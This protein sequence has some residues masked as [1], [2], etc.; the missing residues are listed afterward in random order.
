MMTLEHLVLALRDLLGSPLQIAAAVA[1]GLAFA[2]AMGSALSRT[3]LP[4]RWLAVAANVGLLVFGLVSPSLPALL[5]AVALLPVTFVRAIEITQLMRRM[6]RSTL[7]A[8]Q[9]TLWLKPYMKARKLKAGQILFSKGDKAEYLYLLMQGHLEL[10]EIQKPL[11][12]GHI[13]GEIAL[14]SPERV[15]T[16]TARCVTPCTILQI[17]D[18]TVK[19]LYYQ[20]PSFG[21][22]LIDLLASRL[23]ADVARAEAQVDRE[24]QLTAQV[25]QRTEELDQKNAELVQAMSSLETVERIA[26]HDLKTPLGSLVA[27]AG[28][29]RAGHR[30]NPQD[31]DVLRMM[32]AAANRALR[33]VN[34]SLDMF[35][36]ESGSYVSKPGRIDLPAVVLTVVQD[37]TLQ[38]ESKA[39]VLRVKVPGQ[40]I[41]ANAEESLCYSILANLLKNAVEAARAGSIV[42][43][44][45]LQSDTVGVRIHNEGA[46]PLALRSN[47]FMKFA[48]SGKADG[49]GMGAYSS[50]L[51]ARMQGGSLTM[52]TSEVDG[53]TLNLTLRRWDASQLDVTT[54]TTPK[55][56]KD[57][58]DEAAGT[59]E[60]ARGTL[61]HHHGATVLRRRVLV[62]DDDEF[63]RLILQ[64]Q[65]A[66]F[67]LEVHAAINGL[68]ALEQIKTNRPDLIVM[69]MDMPV[70]GGAEALRL[71]RAHQSEHRQDPSVIVAYSAHDDAHSQEAHLAQGFNYSVNKPG[72]QAQWQALL[73]KL[74]AIH[75]LPNFK[76]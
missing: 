38:A 35:R 76:S 65:F 54:V 75:A 8:D 23:S 1:V 5:M 30:L 72:T 4:L 16:M 63:N 9:V 10:V 43:V 26:R 15:R 37:L 42:S 62:V 2:F 14:F 20:H 31:D 56:E 40:P 34:L 59:A 48:T 17:H 33:M 11:A 49:T 71:I 29:L 45:V 67:P 18:N 52:E 68:N 69:D 21:V 51:L 61:A 7:A 73:M 36:M 12:S 74:D 57:E 60:D 27:A 6:Q 70:M 32:E 44:T 47:F 24:Q 41:L 13:F 46:V 53:T 58:K 3:M 25:Q 39:V 22:H 19:Q 28:L 66:E 55:T 50:H 64:E